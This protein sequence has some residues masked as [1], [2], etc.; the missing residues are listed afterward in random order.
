[1]AGT[2][3]LKV[4]LIGT[5][6]MGRVHSIAY[7]ILGSFFPELPTVRRGV[8]VDVTEALA[9]RGAHQFGYDEWSLDWRQTIARPD[10][11]IVDIVTPN[12]S[13]RPIAEYALEL[14]KHVICEKPLALTAQEARCMADK[15]REAKGV[16]MVVFNY[17]RCPAVLQ[18]KRLIEEG[19]IG[20]IL[21]F[22]ALYLQD[23]AIPKESPWTWRFSAA[24]AGSGALGD[25][26]SHA[27][28]IALY[29]VG[30][31][32]G[33][34]AAA[35]TFVH[36]R[37]R[38]SGGA[39]QMEPVDVD[40]VTIALLRFK[41][42]AL[43]TLEASR[44]AY[45]HKN[46][47]TFEVSGRKGAVRFSWERRNELHFYSAEDRADVQGFRTIICGPA[48]PS[49]ELFWPIPGLGTAYIETQVLQA[50][51]FVRAIVEGAEADT[52]FEHGWQIQNAMETI[53]AAAKTG[54]WKVVAP[55]S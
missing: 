6:F 20:E 40:D 39:V 28:D 26:G 2:S 48:Q 7:A 35:E 1:M 13:H 3:E 53:L 34:A 9:R 46:H 42:G 4:A 25:I 30:D 21:S 44:F 49:G 18:A 22:R 36:S 15:A 50:G 10:I 38:A 19:A 31:I 33:V 16:D 12:D 52:S 47:L 17:R 29:L 5:G 45:G 8:V 55:A 23:W 43:G 51:D 54:T 32:E 41:C 24:Q 37:P 14:G 11:D 27:L